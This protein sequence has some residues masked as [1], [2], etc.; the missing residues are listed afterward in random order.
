MYSHDCGTGA[1]PCKKYLLFG[2]INLQVL[3]FKIIFIS[4]SGHFRR[5]KYEDN[6][7]GKLIFERLDIL[8]LENYFS[9]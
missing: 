6:F 3:L 5:C 4:F 2:K 1:P 8:L 7:I 9:L